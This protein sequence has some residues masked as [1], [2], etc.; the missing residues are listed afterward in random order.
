VLGMANDDKPQLIAA[1]SDDLVKRV[2]AGNLIKAIAP[3]VGGGGGGRPNMAQAG[4]KDASKLGEALAHAR[5]WIS[6]ALE[7]GN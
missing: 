4:G 3:T 2:H 6:Q 7:K 5:T 1:V